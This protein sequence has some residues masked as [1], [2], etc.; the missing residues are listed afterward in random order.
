MDGGELKII[1]NKISAGHFDSYKEALGKSLS[2]KQAI[3]LIACCCTICNA[4]IN[5]SDKL[6]EQDVIILVKNC[7][8]V[9]TDVSIEEYDSYLQSI[10]F[11][12]K[13]LLKKNYKVVLELEGEI[14]PHF[15]PEVL[16]GKQQGIYGALCELIRVEIINKFRKEETDKRELISIG[17][18]LSRILMKS[19]NQKFLCEVIQSYGSYLCSSNVDLKLQYNYV[20]Y[21]CDLL[22]DIPAEVLCSSFLHFIRYGIN[23]FSLHLRN[24][25]L[26]NAD[27]LIT[28]LLLITPEL[29]YWPN[30]KEILC[31][32]KHLIN[33]NI[34]VEHLKKYK[35]SFVTSAQLYEK[36]ENFLNLCKIISLAINSFSY[37]CKNHDSENKFC[38]FNVHLCVYEIIDEIMDFMIHL[39]GKKTVNVR[40]LSE[41]TI[42][43]SNLFT[44][45]LLSSNEQEGLT[46][47]VTS[48]LEKYCKFL[49]SLK[50]CYEK[51]DI[52][53]SETA[54]HLYNLGVIFFRNG[55]N[56]ATLSICHMIL[57]Y[58]SQLGKLEDQVVL[59]NT[60]GLLSSVYMKE[61]KYID[62]FTWNSLQII[63]STEESSKRSVFHKLLK[64]KA[65][66]KGDESS[67][68]VQELTVCSV[69]QHIPS[70]YK[71]YIKRIL[72]VQ[73]Q[74]DLLINEL[75]I[76]HQKWK[77]KVPMMSAFRQLC[78]I[79]D[80]LTL[81][82][83]FINIF[84]DWETHVHENVVTLLEKIF[85]E[86]EKTI[87][88]SKSVN[89]SVFLL[90]IYFFRYKI[91][92]IGI[93]AKNVQEMNKTTTVPESP[94]YPVDIMPA[95][96][97][98]KCDIVSCY[99]GL[100]INGNK[101]M[102]LEKSLYE[103]EEIITSNITMSSFQNID[104]N[105]IYTLAMNLALEFHLHSDVYHSFKAFYLAF[106]IAVCMDKKILM[107]ECGGY[108]LRYLKDKK[109]E[110]QLEEEVS[111]LKTEKQNFKYLVQ[112]YI[113]LSYLHLFENNVP[114]AV[115]QFKTALEYLEDINPVNEKYHWRT[116]I[117]LEL[118]HYKLMQA[119]KMCKL[120]TELKSSFGPLM[121]A[122]DLMVQKYNTEVEW[123]PASMVLFF[124][125]LESIVKMYHDLKMPREVRY[126]GKQSLTLAQQH[127]I[128]MLSVKFL[129]YLAHADFR[130]ECWCDCR[131]K[132]DGMSEIMLLEKDK[133]SSSTNDAVECIT[134]GIQEIVIN[135]AN[136]GNFNVNSNPSSPVLIGNPYKHPQF[137]DHKNCECFKCTSIEYQQLAVS[138][139]HLEALWY[140]YKKQITLARSFFRGTSEFYQ[141]LSVKE[142]MIPKNLHLTPYLSI[143]TQT[144]SLKK[145][146]NEYNYQ[147]SIDYIKF[148][149]SS[150]AHELAKKH[151]YSLSSQLKLEKNIYPNLYGE[152]LLLKLGL[153]SKMRVREKGVNLQLFIPCENGAV[154]KTPE[155]CVS[156]TV[157]EDKER[158]LK[159][160]SIIPPK[161]IKF[162][163][164]ELAVD[165]KDKNTPSKVI[166]KL[167]KTPLRTPKSRILPISLRNTPTPLFKTPCRKPSSNESN[168]FDISHTIN[169]ELS[170]KIASDIKVSKSKGDHLKRPPLIEILDP[171]IC[172]NNSLCN[173]T[174]ETKGSVKDHCFDVKTKLLTAK[175]KKKIKETPISSDSCD[176][177]QTVRRS[178]RRKRL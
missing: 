27:N 9:I 148:L 101:M 97:Y 171:P 134:E 153:I 47:Q 93:I 35:T 39:S 123:G 75:E 74:I 121:K 136:M 70:E 56:A 10:F 150:G 169:R 18:L 161:V 68:L 176:E 124:D 120:S 89:H 108:L 17:N 3:Y 34:E 145:V 87:K 173:S 147:C 50:G 49:V 30:F 122:H 44:K 170:K 60:M 129:S 4:S 160:K 66:A 158:S 139:Y 163:L 20:M 106:K 175:I 8:K 178:A 16:T 21:N 36:N 58:H 133:I 119:S 83:V 166:N 132:L 45:L 72:N 88:N 116:D 109:L 1:G 103:L 25:I 82:K 143:S 48:L 155:K 54:V 77:S 91:Q 76:Y 2:Q 96:A 174:T 64:I 11:I 128:P 41:L 159:I 126:F 73:T 100:N 6:S 32:C 118:L 38:D 142:A 113:H 52:A 135:E 28:K 26:E 63:Y 137:S 23:I 14:I 22:K 79:A 95:D 168:E 67:A 177:M 78:N 81:M 162:S 90:F 61:K 51:L 138:R 85:L 31:L 152:V 5:E 156:K 69:I 13:F 94:E 98:V 125:V 172:E 167:C 144:N 151:C 19:R 62:A 65:A 110:K 7:S 154:F 53:W 165:N 131:V 55:D 114:S 146:F 33:K 71:C 92:S 99:E 130:S 107:L 86:Y 140:M 40:E 59:P 37:F 111:N 29:N 84:S 15:I 157:L 24:G 80:N 105:K 12:C 164:A 127:Q 46:I 57:N 115:K 42:S 104:L 102:N 117:S 43:I 141:I 112:Y 149:Y